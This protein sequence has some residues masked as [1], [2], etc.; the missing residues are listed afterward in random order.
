[1]E[2]SAACVP[3]IRLHGQEPFLSSNV[4]ICVGT[5]AAGTLHVLGT[6]SQTRTAEVQVM[7]LDLEGVVSKMVGLKDKKIFFKSDFRLDFFK[8][9][10]INLLSNHKDALLLLNLMQRRA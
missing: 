7:A 3:L 1:M 2:Q 8:A 10:L 5:P 6:W 4:L 9:N